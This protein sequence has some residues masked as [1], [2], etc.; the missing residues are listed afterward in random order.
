MT[1]KRFLTHFWLSVVVSLYII[2]VWAVHRV[3]SWYGLYMT[4]TE[5]IHTIMLW[6]AYT[7]FCNKLAARPSYTKIDIL[8][9][10]I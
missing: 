3:I 9:K 4:Y 2:Y 6:R 5:Q 7:C 1:K 8:V 10:Y